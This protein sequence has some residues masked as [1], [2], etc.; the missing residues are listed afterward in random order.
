MGKHGA[1]SH[2]SRGED[3]DKNM[4]RRIACRQTG[5]GGGNHCPPSFYATSRSCSAGL[6]PLLQQTGLS[7]SVSWWLWLQPTQTCK[8]CWEHTCKICWEQ[9]MN[10][11]QIMKFQYWGLGGRESWKVPGN[12][13][14]PWERVSPAR[15]TSMARLRGHCPQPSDSLLSILT[16]TPTPSG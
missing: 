1:A 5:W 8:I 14:Q 4:R 9:I 2:L 7:H 15:C 13:D 12:R 10:I 11:N 6:A 16:S 3:R